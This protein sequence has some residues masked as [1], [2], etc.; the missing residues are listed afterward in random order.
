[1][2]GW[3]A[4]SR[5][6]FHGSFSVRDTGADC[7]VSLLPERSDAFDNRRRGH[8]LNVLDKLL[9]SALPTWRLCKF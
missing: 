7:A 5:H 3:R 8:R 9:I 6:L 1:M 4:D 2:P